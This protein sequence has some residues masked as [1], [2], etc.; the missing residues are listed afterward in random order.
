M[1]EAIGKSVQKQRQQQQQQQQ[2]QQL[3]RINFVGF[4]SLVGPLK[5]PM[6]G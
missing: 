1:A 3:F 2:Q 5:S 6:V 4:S